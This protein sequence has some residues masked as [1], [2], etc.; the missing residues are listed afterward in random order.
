MSKDGIKTIEIKENKHRREQTKTC[1]LLI[2]EGQ[3]LNL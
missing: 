2:P 1:I 3:E